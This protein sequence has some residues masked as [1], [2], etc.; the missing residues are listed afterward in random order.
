MT[1]EGEFR[2]IYKLDVI[3]IPTNKEMIRKDNN[4]VIY[5]NELA[6]FR[7]VVEDIKESH[8]KGQPVLVGTV[9]IEKSESLSRML[10]KEGIKHEVL[11]AKYHEKE[12]EIIAQAGKYGAVTIATN[13]AGRG[14]DIMLG[15]NTEYM[16]KQAMKKKGFSEELINESTSFAETDDEEILEARKTFNT[17][18][19]KY[20]EDIKEERQKVIQTGGLKIIG[21]ERHESRRIDNQLRGRSGRQGDA[22]ESRFYISLEDDLMKLFGGDMVTNVYNTLKA[23]EN[24]PI[25][26]GLLSKAIESAQKKIEDRNF[27]IRKHVLQYDDVMNAQ[28]EIIYNQRREVL[29]GENVNDNIMKMLEYIANV[30]VERFTVS[31]LSEDWDYEGL[32]MEVQKIFNLETLETIDNKESQ[33]QKIIEELI[34]KAKES[35][36]EKEEKIGSEDFREVERR[37]LLKV[38]D[39]KWMDHIDAMDELKDGIGLRA[40][41]NK[42]PVI[43]YRTEGSQMFEVMI[44]DIK[45]NVVML[46]L[47][48]EKKE[49]VKPEQ[50]IKITGEYSSDLDKIG[51]ATTGAKASSTPVKSEK[52]VGRNDLCPCRKRI[53]I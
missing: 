51:G 36:E 40:Y 32:K 53:K 10:K 12:A 23:D 21:T 14:T 45:E 37:V 34:E 49:Q 8:Q 47:H 1:E 35:Y 39:E 28:R 4:D 9:S 42:N 26:M 41:G 43:E 46:M 19:E 20:N 2:E 13:M 38:V 25:Q 5:K 50:V 31:E 24:M 16:A 52:T 15:G 44:D 3:E 6:K 17:L 29:D 22:G 18:Q 7:A 33:K 27:S 48:L 30:T 11:N